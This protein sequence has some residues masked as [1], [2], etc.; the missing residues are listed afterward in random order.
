MSQLGR[1]YGLHLIKQALEVTE[2]TSYE[3]TPMPD[4]DQTQEIS[5]LFDQNQT[6]DPM[7]DMVMGG[8]EKI[9]RQQD[10]SGAVGVDEKEENRV[11]G[12]KPVV[13]QDSADPSVSEAWSEHD[14]FRSF[15]HALVDGAASPGPAI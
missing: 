10:F 4:G 12:K 5:T 8:P 7:S 6:R 11:P 14:S 2:S 9:S 13:S 1:Q 3:H 15:P